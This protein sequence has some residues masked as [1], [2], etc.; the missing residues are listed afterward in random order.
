VIRT[1]HLQ[2][3]LAAGEAPEHVPSY[4]DHLLGAA[5][6]A[7]SV[8]GGPVDRALRTGG[9]F[10]VLGVYGAR[11]ALGRV[12][13]QGSPR[14]WN[15][16]EH[17]LE[18]SRTYQVELS[19]ALAAHRVVD[20]LR[21]VRGVE[22]ASVQTLAAAPFAVALA[23][24]THARALADVAWAPHERIHA[25]E[26]HRLEAGD[27]RVTVGLVDTGVSLGH[28]E[29]Q[30]K[31]LAGYDAVDLGI[32]EAAGLRL[33]GDSRG[34]DFTPS[35][36][37]GHGSHVAGVIGATG[38]ELP[39]GV[40]GLSL[41]LPVRVLAA[42][43]TAGAQ[44]P[45]GIGAEANINCG[46]KVAV[47]LGADVL[48]LSFG[49][50]EHD[51]DA[52][53]PKPQAPVVAYAKRYG[54][55][56]VAASGNSGAVERF[57]PAA[58]PDVIAVGSV[59]AAGKRSTF[60]S[61]GDHV[62]LCAPGESIVSCGIEGLREGSGTSYA[63]PFV[64]GAAALAIAHAR[65]RG[66]ALTAQDVRDLLVSTAAPLPG[67]TAHETGAGLLDVAAALRKLDQ[68]GSAS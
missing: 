67:S 1:R 51:I 53:A 68:G 7:T 10:R 36:E 62:A 54:C 24:R 29:F 47:D 16:A 59:D 38:W 35:D 49:T 63:A 55:V 37:V 3:T 23:E 2:V 20:G 64:T 18:L 33:V 14:Y 61:Y 25:P 26:A 13:E 52:E 34:D 6:A 28:P 56:L 19:D 50:S 5:R 66:L 31:L 42:A 40:A 43:M 41:M 27:E 32:D 21:S 46:M 4:L 30:R 12:G 22:S 8:D 58:L 65:R 45:S 39:P 15:D 17:E 11:A 57:Y 44:R 60:S 9:S 48:N